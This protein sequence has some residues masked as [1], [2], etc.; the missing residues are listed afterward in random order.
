MDDYISRQA[1]TEIIGGYMNRLAKHIGAPT[2]NERYSYARGVLL[3]VNIDINALPSAQPEIVKCH[4]CIHW[5]RDT[6]RQNSND[7]GWWNEAICERY[8]DE[9]WESW[10]DADW[11][12]ADAERRT[13]DT[14]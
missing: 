3:G 6:V 11:Y 5:D 2:D 9:I 14:D 13:D 1:A 12:C 4:E 7:A 10:K 8:S